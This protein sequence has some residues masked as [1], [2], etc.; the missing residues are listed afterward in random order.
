MST[1]PS[2][3]PELPTS[4]LGRDITFDSDT[5]STERQESPPSQV[6]PTLPSPR[7]AE[8]GSNAIT[9]G[10][11]SQQQ[12]IAITSAL[13]KIRVRAPLGPKNYIAWAD[14]I[15]TGLASIQYDDY[16]RSDVCPEGMGGDLF[17]VIKK[18][19]VSWLLCSMDENE[20]RR[21]K[22]KITS[23]NEEGEPITIY[24]PARLWKEVRKHYLSKSESVKLACEI[25]LDNLKQ[26]PGQDLIQHI[27]AF[28]HKVNELISQDG[29]ISEISKS[30]KL[31]KSLNNTWHR[32]G[33][34]F[35]DNNITDYQEMCHKLRASY[36]TAILMRGP[37]TS[38]YESRD[39][40]TITSKARLRMKCTPSRCFGGDHHTPENCFRRP[41]NEGMRARWEEELKRSGKWRSSLQPRGSERGQTTSSNAEETLLELEG[42]RLEDR[43]ITYNVVVHGDYHC[44]SIPPF[45][46]TEDKES[47]YGLLDTGASH[48]MFNDDSFF[49]EGSFISNQDPAAKLSLAG[50]DATLDITG[51]GTVTIVNSLGEQVKFGDCLLVPGLTRNLIAGGRM[52]RAGATTTLLKDPEFKI[53]NGK[54][55]LLTGYFIGDGSLMFVK[56]VKVKISSSLA[57]RTDQRLTALKLHYRLGHLNKR[58]LSEMLKAGLL[59]DLKLKGLS[60]LDFDVLDECPIC[61]LAKSHKLPFVLTRPRSSKPGHNVH[62]DLSGIYRVPSNHQEQY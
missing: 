13:N 30:H 41:G 24:Q 39:T 5:E 2:T 9:I 61:P 19:L 28:D 11:L 35:L 23:V 46:M 58:Y 29:A 60:S 34:D 44:S 21:F 33:M 50:G 4:E 37:Q 54:K 57:R 42:L 43:D 49:D 7:M 36:E 38:R 10:T 40:A 16:I 8:Q 15:E 53:V 3:P 59:D 32:K 31:V 12:A 27:E 1:P 47:R 56:L 6:P 17:K 26:L 55:E 25:A 18:S 62:I 48:H 52:I 51:F 20:A 22:A 45:A 14:N